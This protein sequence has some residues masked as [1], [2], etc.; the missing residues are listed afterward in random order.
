M[1][2]SAMHLSWGL[3]QI[4]ITN[5]TWIIGLSA[6]LHIFIMLSW[7]LTAII[8]SIVGAMIVNMWKKTVIYVSENIFFVSD[9]VLIC[10]IT[11]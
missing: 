3:W 1:M 5:Q 10:S 2:A 9:S 6:S 11:L 7:F 8:G 4:A